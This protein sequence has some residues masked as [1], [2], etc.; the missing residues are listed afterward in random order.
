[1]LV[2]TLLSCCLL[3]RLA[4]AK[5]QAIVFFALGFRP[6]SR[7]SNPHAH[8]REG[9]R[10]VEDDMANL[11]INSQLVP[12]QRKI[13][14]NRGFAPLAIKILEHRGM[15]RLVSHAKGSC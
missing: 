7:C 14:T 15:S 5:L 3:E 8:V 4:R 13:Y 11:L 9:R 12:E 10:V 1:L 2:N 6:G